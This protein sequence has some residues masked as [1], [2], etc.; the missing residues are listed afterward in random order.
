[1]KRILTILMAAMLLLA[2][3]ACGSQPAEE[4]AEETE[5]AAGELEEAAEEIAEEAEETAEAVESEFISDG[6]V[7]LKFADVALP[8]GWT[9]VSIYGHEVTFERD[10]KVPTDDPDFFLTRKLTISS[11]S[12]TK[13]AEE[14]IADL[15]SNFGGGNAIDTVTIGDVEWVRM[16]PDGVSDQFYLAT[17]TSE[18]TTVEVSGM[19][20]QLDDPEVLAIIEGILPH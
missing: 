6:Q 9:P 17:D 19:F 20:A 7:H 4:A 1:M 8:T 10:E 12:S 14:Q 2:L 18:G 15:D 16:I 3:A 13:T 11:T 5:A